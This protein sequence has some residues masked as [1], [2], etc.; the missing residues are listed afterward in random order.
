MVEIVVHTDDLARSID[1][2]TPAFPDDV[3]RPVLHLLAELATER[4]GQAALTS[5]LTRRER[6]PDTVSA[7]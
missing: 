7:F 2:P 4:H 1:V 6:M 3:Y 5:A